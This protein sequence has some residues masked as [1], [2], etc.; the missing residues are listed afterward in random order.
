[1]SVVFFAFPPLFP[2]NPMLKIDFFFAILRTLRIFFELPEVLIAI[3]TSFEVPNA[4]RFLEKIL[5][6]E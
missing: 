6:K 1:M 4:S 2:K 3:K 5:S